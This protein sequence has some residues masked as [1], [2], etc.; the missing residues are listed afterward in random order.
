MNKK[1]KTLEEIKTI[2]KKLKPELEQ[3]YKV[4]EIG[5]FGSWVKGK[6]KK[7]SDIDILID[8]Y[9]KPD[10]LTYIEIENF[11]SRKLKRKVDLVLKSALKPY[12]GKII[13][14]ETL[15]L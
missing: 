13:L 2:L 3:R 15:Y 10:L 5:I 1:V 11:L 6:Q 14:K 7:R 12:I 8:F 4:K 9:E